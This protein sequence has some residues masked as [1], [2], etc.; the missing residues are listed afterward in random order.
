MLTFSATYFASVIAKQ[1]QPRAASAVRCLRER[2][3]G[4]HTLREIADAYAAIPS[5]RFGKPAIS[6]DTAAEIRLNYA[7]VSTE[8]GVGGGPVPRT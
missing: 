4:T 7:F 1:T 6:L 5:V 2:V 3:S 8:S